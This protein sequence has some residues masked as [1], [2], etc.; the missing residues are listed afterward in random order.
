M[1]IIKQDLL[2]LFVFCFTLL[3]SYDFVDLLNGTIFVFQVLNQKFDGFG[4][5]CKAALDF[6]IFF[7]SHSTCFIRCNINLD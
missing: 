2:I 7:D 4:C 6:I 1:K 5:V 3:L